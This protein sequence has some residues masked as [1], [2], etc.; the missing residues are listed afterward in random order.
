MGQRL[1]PRSVGPWSHDRWGP[2]IVLKP[3]LLGD[4][5]RQLARLKR[6]KNAQ[7]WFQYRDSDPDEM[8]LSELFKLKPIT[9]DSPLMADARKARRQTLRKLLDLKL[10]TEDDVIPVFDWLDWTDP[11]GIGS[12]W[13]NIVGERV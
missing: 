1:R 9:G 13:G 5:A 3:G 2:W 4:I 6:K 12:S 10:I 8:F 11:F 7:F